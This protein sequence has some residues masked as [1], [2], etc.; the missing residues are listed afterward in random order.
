MLFLS[1]Q[2]VEVWKMNL[3]IGVLLLV[4]IVLLTVWQTIDPLYRLVEDFAKE[5]VYE[6]DLEIQPQL[7]HCEATHLPIWLG[8]WNFSDL[9]GLFLDIALKAVDT[10][11]N[12]SK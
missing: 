3:M 11:G 2:K 1:K 4:D 7:E 5:E 8:K 6:E 9:S 10:I 12:Y